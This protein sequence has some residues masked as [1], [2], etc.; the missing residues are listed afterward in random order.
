[1][2]VTF[3][4]SKRP[5]H[6]EKTNRTYYNAHFLQPDDSDAACVELL[7]LDVTPEVHG[8]LLAVSL[9]E[10]LS[11]EVVPRVFAGRVQGLQVIGFS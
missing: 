10:L 6:S 2:K 4:G 3:I 5:Y 11:L 9:G 7:S 8:R 1:M